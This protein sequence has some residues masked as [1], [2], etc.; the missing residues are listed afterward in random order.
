MRSLCFELLNHQFVMAELEA[1]IASLQDGGTL[2]KCGRSGKPH[3]RPFKLT[4][5]RKR[6]AYSTPKKKEGMEYGT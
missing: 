2:L 1:N 6:L 5:D 3:F 4:K